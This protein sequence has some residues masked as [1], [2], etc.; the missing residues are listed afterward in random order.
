VCIPLGTSLPQ[1]RGF[2]ERYGALLLFP[3]PTPRAGRAGIHGFRSAFVAEKGGP[4]GTGPWSPSP[5][6]AWAH[7]EGTAES[8]TPDLRDVEGKVGRKIPEGLLRGLRGECELGTSGDVLL[9]GAP[10]TGH[11]LGDKIMALRM[12]LVSVGATGHGERDI[13]RGRGRFPEL[14]WRRGSFQDQSIHPGLKAE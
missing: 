13:C 1:L 6:L 8:Q 11:G 5:V 3:H 7:M 2:S 14:G 12:E 4:L 9:P 10:S